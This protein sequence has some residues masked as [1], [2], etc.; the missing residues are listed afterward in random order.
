MTAPAPQAPPGGREAGLRLDK[1][2]WHARFFK[3]RTKASEFCARGRVRLNRRL[4]EKPSV[5]VRVGDVVILP[6]ADPGSGD[7]IRVLRV[8][9]LGERRGP[10]AEA[11]GLYADLAA[12]NSPEFGAGSAITTIDSSIEG[13]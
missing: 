10:P 13:P 11:R 8:L 2:L 12:G 9:A 6:L 7:S 5:T 3:T 4:V 1:W